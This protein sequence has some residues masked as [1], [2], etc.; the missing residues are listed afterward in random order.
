MLIEDC[1]AATLPH[2]HESIKLFTQMGHGIFGTVA[3][4]DDLIEVIS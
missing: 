3:R 2:N 1:C 4:S